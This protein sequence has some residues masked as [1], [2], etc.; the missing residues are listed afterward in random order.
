M[1]GG[2]EASQHRS[3]LLVPRVATDPDYAGQLS[4]ASR[5]SLRLQ[6]G[7]MSADEQR[8]FAGLPHAEEALALRRWDDAAKT[9]GQRTPPLAY[10]LT[11]LDP[12]RQR[13]TATE[14]LE[15][16]PD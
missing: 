14:A 4:P 7:P 8:W 15:L 1:P 3:K 11:M 6:G 2:E 12:L 16:G 5:H 13:H 9:P 10:Y